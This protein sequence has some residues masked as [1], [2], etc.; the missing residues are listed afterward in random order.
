[1]D[2]GLFREPLAGIRWFS[3]TSNGVTLLELKDAPCLALLGDVG[4]GKSTTV[5]REA[6]EL[7]AAFAGQKHAVVYI[8][9]KRLSETQIERRIFGHP[10]VEGWLRG[11]HSL[12]LFLDSLDE[13][14]RRI[15][16]LEVLLVDE[17]GRRIRDETPPLFLRLTCRSAEWRGD[18]GKTLERLSSKRLASN[19]PVQ[20]V[21][22]APLSAN[23]V[24]EAAKANELDGDRLLE[25]VIAKQAQGLASHPITLEM[26]LQIYRASGDFPKSRV[27]LYR[28]GCL[29]L[30]ADEQAVFSAVQKRKTTPQQRFA[31]ASRMA[32]L[33]VLTNRFQINGDAEHPLSRVDVL[34]IAEI[35]GHTDEKV[36]GDSVLVDRDTVAETLQTALFAER[37]EGAQTWRHQSYA[38]YLAAYYVAR[39]GLSA[40]QTA[41]ILTDTA[42]NSERIIPQLEETACWTAEIISEVFEILAARNADVFLRCDST[43]WSDRSRILLVENYLQLVRLH[44]AEQLDWQLKHRFSQLAHPDL[45]TQLG[46]IIT[47]RIENPLVRESAIDIAG[48]CKLA[49][50]APELVGVFLDTTEIFRVRKHAAVALWHARNDEIRTLLRGRNVGDWSGDIDDD[51][52]GYYLQIMWPTHVSLDELM[53]LTSPKR[54]YYTGSYK[55]FLE[56]ELPKSLPDAE[57]PRMLD[58]LRENKVSFDI[59]GAFGYLPS[60][61]FVRAL[62]Q[63]IV[64]AIL[65][66]VLRLL[67]HDEHQLHHLFRGKLEPEE[68]S[69]QARLCFWK[70]VVQ[71]ELDLQKLV[72]Y[73]DMHSA[74]M[75]QRDDAIPFIGEYRTSADERI[76]NRWRML[77][78]WVFSMEDAAIMDTFSDLA[79]T[80]MAVAQDLA[81]RTSCPLVPDEQN[82]MKQ[83]YERQ[84][85]RNQAEQGAKPSL[86]ELFINAL[87]AFESGA[88]HAFWTVG[89]LL[90]FDPEKPQ[91]GFV[92][93]TIQFSE[94][95]AWKSLPSEVRERILRGVPVYLR[96]Q[97]V[98]DAQVWDSAHRYRPYDV[99]SALLVLLY[100]ENRQQLDALTSED[101]GKW[102][103]V[104]FAYSS[105]RNG[106]HDEAY[107]AILSSA[108]CKGARTVSRRFKALSGSRDQQRFPAPHYLAFECGVAR[109][110]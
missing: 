14:W 15:D 51:L 38:E 47:N 80:D 32:A 81:A 2:D 94:G 42:D 56:Y 96:A 78:F 65:E 99:V 106:S 33:S 77:I 30:C 86:T 41:A 58:W 18:A 50:L 107:K 64:V 68:I 85:K 87:D 74:G 60:K 26:L 73:A 70:A 52:R 11:D 6:E 98:D 67:S 13:C 48:Y 89:E 69:A 62:D 101:W 17:L 1:M 27:D 59:T 97:T 63:M 109:R 39:R 108:S 35:V 21:V 104:L 36:G 34:E 61:L 20:I 75:L 57:L 82:W 110:D 5:E 76:R 45:A 105:R 7:K 95:K 24:R 71:S 88:I 55:M 83:N 12:T 22:L 40:L 28:D 72:N 4:M 25:R 44:E 100:D 23:N 102:I 37:I 53:P 93:P 29:R 8:D 46:P 31:I 43:Y 9:L 92:F 10:E 3:E 84:Q 66:A 16:A 91:D 19:P 79:G 90:D 54:R 103:T 49:S